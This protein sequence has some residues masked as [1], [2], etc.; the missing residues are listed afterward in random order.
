MP[1][2]NK[3]LDPRSATVLISDPDPALRQS[4][5]SLLTRAG[6][7][8]LGQAEEAAELLALTRKLGPKL[9]ILGQNSAEPADLDPV[10]E[11]RT[12]NS[13]AIVL[14]APIASVSWVRSARAAG[15][16][17]LLGRPPRE[18]DLLAAVE[19]SLSRRVE[20][21]RLLRD[22]E[23]LQQRIETFALVARARELLVRRN[24]IA[25]EE[26][27]RRLLRQAE[28]T[29]RTLRSVA[30]AVLLAETVAPNA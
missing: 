4:I 13:L 5:A 28:R 6:Q 24:G 27:Q 17:A 20:V 22:N 29:D 1:Q 8:V 11:L 7:C 12:N 2:P 18:C 10:R 25:D 16:D 21:G 19:T 9:V 30:E 23:Q 15:V 3:E 14:L 26:A